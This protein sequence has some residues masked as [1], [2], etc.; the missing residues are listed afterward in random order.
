VLGETSA[1]DSLNTLSSDIALS[2]QL[3]ELTLPLRRKRYIPKPD[4]SDFQQGSWA[5]LSADVGIPLGPFQE[6]N[7]TF[8]RISKIL[9]LCPKLQRIPVMI[10]HV[11]SFRLSDDGA[12]ATVKD[13]SGEMDASI[14]H[15]VL[16]E[17]KSDLVQGSS[18]II[19]NVSLFTVSPKRQVLNIV[20]RNV[21]CVQPPSLAHL[22][23]QF[24]PNFVATSDEHPT[25]ISSSFQKLRDLQAPL[26]TSE[27]LV[28][29]PLIVSSVRSS[30]AYS[31][32][33]SRT[34]EF[35]D[36][37]GNFDHIIPSQVRFA[38]E[39]ARIPLQHG[40]ESL[41][42]SS[43]SSQGFVMS[44][45]VPGLSQYLAAKRARESA[46]ASEPARSASF[47]INLINLPAA[48]APQQLVD[49]TQA[50]D[51]HSPFGPGLNSASSSGRSVVSDNSS[52]CSRGG[53]VRHW[54]S[55]S[56]LHTRPNRL[57]DP[58]DESVLEFD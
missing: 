56:S 16:D 28:T 41:S 50:S 53:P 34:S 7:V 6:S 17:F 32:Q 42:S 25:L 47:P 30:A 35:A 4:D 45:V 52:I 19:R 11:K 37:M 27:V 21:I 58:D 12:F 14:H 5:K 43:T 54:Q 55:P 13:P 48:L 8:T 39:N 24:L 51:N 46:A 40:T 10:L 18:L 23:T 20:L 9:S 3:P 36:S 57:C 29:S 22:S 38:P 15:L 31:F 1:H 33:Q 2:T 49:S 26:S 44:R